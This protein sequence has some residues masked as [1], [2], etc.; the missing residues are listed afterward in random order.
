MALTGGAFAMVVAVADPNRPAVAAVAVAAITIT[1]L[2]LP[3]D[4]WG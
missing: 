4:T 2:A 1:V 3:A